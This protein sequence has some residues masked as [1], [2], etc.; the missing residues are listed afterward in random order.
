MNYTRF[1]TVTKQGT[2]DY[3]GDKCSLLIKLKHLPGALAGV[4]RALCKRGNKYDQD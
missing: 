3:Q 1:V 2:A 4:L